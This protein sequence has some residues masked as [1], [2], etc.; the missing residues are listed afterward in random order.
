MIFCE[1]FMKI[2]FCIAKNFTWS[3]KNSGDSPELRAKCI[4]WYKINFSDHTK[5]W[6]DSV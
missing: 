2:G 1:V 5:A 3:S 4:F 6:W